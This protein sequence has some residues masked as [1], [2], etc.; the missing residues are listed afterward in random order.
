MTQPDNIREKV[1]MEERLVSEI[2]RIIDNTYSVGYYDGE[3]GRKY[4]DE[5]TMAGLNMNLGSDVSK[6][7]S[8]I[9][10]AERRAAKEAELQGRLGIL[11]RVM[12]M[13]KT[14]PSQEKI[15]QRCEK[16]RD[17]YQQEL[18]SLQPN[19]EEDK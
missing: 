8:L 14:Y 5:V 10:E 19:S 4:Q 13:L 16:L 9:T 11:Y 6:I 18:E 2:G 15:Y 17:N 7:L 1:T 3:S 12:T